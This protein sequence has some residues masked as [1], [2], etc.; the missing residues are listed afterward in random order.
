MSIT[1]HVAASGALS[2][3]LLLP[4]PNSDGTFV[5]I[6]L[7]EDKDAG[8]GGGNDPNLANAGRDHDYQHLP[9]RWQNQFGQRWKSSGRNG[10][11]C[12]SADNDGH[13]DSRLSITETPG[14]PSQHAA[15]HHHRR[16]HHTHQQHQRRARRPS[17]PHHTATQHP[18]NDGSA[19]ASLL[20]DGNVNVSEA[21]PEKSGSSSWWWCTTQ[22][23][24]WSCRVLSILAAGAYLT[25]L[26][27]AAGAILGFSTTVTP[28]LQ[29]A[30]E[31]M[32]DVTS[33]RHSVCVVLDVTYTLLC[34]STLTEP[35]ARP[36]SAAAH[37]VLSDTRADTIVGVRQQGGKADGVSS[38][39]TLMM[40]GATPQLSPTQICAALQ[41]VL[42][43]SE[44][45]STRTQNSLASVQELRRVHV[46]LEAL[47]LQA[48]TQAQA[49]AQAS[50]LAHS[51]ENG[52]RHDLE[53]PFQVLKDVPSQDLVKEWYLTRAQAR[54]MQSPSPRSRPRSRFAPL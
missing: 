52:E 12:S 53:S 49:R 27:I 48:Q 32:S 18:S 20:F 3:P 26:G 46:I 45:S 8:A 4:T 16:H 29:Q 50:N 39:P 44:Y 1:G 51:R 28:V 43:G 7:S 31:T 35:D 33:L 36:P 13:E 30:S 5:S 25:M 23:C 17:A 14:Q 19:T 2:Q 24:W 54:R 37:A 15:Q 42:C 22:R 9:S 47:Q 21:S 40:P 38:V 11:S 10:D 34:N 41:S 6:P